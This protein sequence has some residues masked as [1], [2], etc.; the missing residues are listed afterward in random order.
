M[1]NGSAWITLG[2]VGFTPSFA[3]YTSIAVNSKDTPYVAFSDGA[4]SNATVMS[5]DGSKWNVVGK[6][7]FS[8]SFAKYTQVAIGSNDTVYAAF[9]DYGQSDTGATVMKYI[10]PPPLGIK[11][12]VNNN[13]EMKVIPNPGHFYSNLIIDMKQND[14]LQLS[15]ISATGN[16]VK[17]LPDVMVQPGEQSVHINLSGLAAGNYLIE[18][19]SKKQGKGTIPFAVE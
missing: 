7:G 19:T 8:S 12:V 9:E 6:R 1:W 11:P 15:I 2:G 5:Y 16:L 17:E 10:P 13:F 3:Y 4:D 18:V 14:H